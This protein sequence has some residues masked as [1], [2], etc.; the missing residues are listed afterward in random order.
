LCFREVAKSLQECGSLVI[1][2]PATNLLGNTHGPLCYSFQ[3][4]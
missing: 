4:L 2:A 1:I 3:A